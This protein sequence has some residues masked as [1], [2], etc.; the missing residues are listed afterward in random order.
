MAR[1]QS[2]AQVPMRFAWHRDACSLSHD[3]ATMP[4]SI[5]RP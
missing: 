5:W 2:A 4:R 3:V 1:G